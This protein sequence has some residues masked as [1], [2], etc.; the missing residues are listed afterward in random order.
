MPPTP[1]PSAATPAPARH[2]G[3][4]LVG[5]DGAI[6]IG[7]R[8]QVS[9]SNAVALGAGSVAN[10]ANTVSIGRSAPSEA[11]STSPTGRSPPAPPTRSIGAALHGQPARCC[12]VRDHARRQRPIDRTELY[13]PR[14]RLWQRRKCLRRGQHRPRRQRHQHRAEPDQQRFDR[15]S[16]A[17]FDTRVINV[18][19]GTDGTVVDMAGTSGNRTVTGVAAGAVTAASTDAV[20]GSQLY[21][22]N[23]QVA[24]NTGAISTLTGQVAANTSD[25][26][27]LSSTIAGISQSSQ[28]T[29][30]N[31]T[32]PAANASGADAIAVGSNAQATQTGSIA[33]GLNAASTG[34]NSIGDRRWRHCNRLGGGLRG[35]IGGQWRRGLWR[36][37]GGDRLALDRGRSEP[38]TIAATGPVRSAPASTK[39]RRRRPCRSAPPA[40]SA[41]LPTSTPASTRRRR[42]RGTDRST[43]SGFQ[44]RRSADCKPRSSTTSARRGAASL[45]GGR[46]RGAAAMPSGGGKNF[47]SPS[48]PDF[49]GQTGCRHRHFD[50]LERR[51]ADRGRWRLFRWRRQRQ[52][53][54]GYPGAEF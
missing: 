1:S 37:G 30:V 36:W 52:Y 12:G 43:V 3:V 19:G 17:K 21:A 15:P 39:H 38:V 34:V 41:G 51:R 4:C 45:P 53:R 47:H 14:H 44:I 16:A 50:R 5:R 13:H 29:R 24:A 27:T 7:N 9:A 28:Y 32:G 10:V 48:T 40:T 35:G 31:S 20:N 33:I 18:G 49:R 54:G 11:P 26:E 2:R 42:Q 8:T 6:A 23:Q 22:T 46:A 25:I